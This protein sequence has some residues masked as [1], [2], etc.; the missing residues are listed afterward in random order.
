MKSFVLL[1]IRIKPYN[2]LF[3]RNILTSSI[4]NIISNK[5]IS[6]EYNVEEDDLDYEQMFIKT[7]FKDIEWG[8]PLR[9][10]KLPEPTRFGD[11]ERKGRCSDY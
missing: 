10:G 7:I 9:G 2:K 5:K 3:C 6:Q 4:H 11:W 8:G 1:S